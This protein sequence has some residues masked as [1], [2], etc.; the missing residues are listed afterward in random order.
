MF[1]DIG[2]AM[3]LDGLPCVSYKDIKRWKYR[4]V[5]IWKCGIIGGPTGI[6]GMDEVD[7]NEKKEKRKN[8]KI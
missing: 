3:N 6:G 2:Q 8:V 1:S 7:E 4:N 5:K